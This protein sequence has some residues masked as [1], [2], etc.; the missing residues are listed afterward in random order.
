MTNLP[1]E[2]LT[3][4]GA[5]QLYRARWTV[6][7]LFREAKG[8][9]HLD[10]VATSNRYVGRVADRDGA[11]DVGGEPSVPQRDAGSAAR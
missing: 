4:D 9:F 5:A 10:C 11:A 2:A 6:E 8:A 7:L 3:A 1:V